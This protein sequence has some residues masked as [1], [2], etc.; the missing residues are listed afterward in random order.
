[1]DPLGVFYALLVF[2][3]IG[4]TLDMFLM[5]F[6]CPEHLPFWGK[7]VPFIVLYTWIKE[8]Y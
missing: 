8:N 7:R 6:D 4:L 2:A 1:M 5:L 3:G